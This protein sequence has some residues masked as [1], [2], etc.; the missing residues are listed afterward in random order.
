MAISGYA[1]IAPKIMT[2]KDINNLF[3]QF[4]ETHAD[5]YGQLFL[6]FPPKGKFTVQDIFGIFDCIVMDIYGNT[7]FVQLT[8]KNN[9]AARVGKIL[10]FGNMNL[11][12]IPSNW[13]IA[14][15]NKRTGLFE[16]DRVSQA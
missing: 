16:V 2:E 3:V 1:K 12:I 7:F 6:W 8:T 15:F 9:R 14:V 4:I 5:S 11:K 10:N 13:L